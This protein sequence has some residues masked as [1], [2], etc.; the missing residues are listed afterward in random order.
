MAFLKGP[1]KSVNKE[2]MDMIDFSVGV[3]PDGQEREDKIA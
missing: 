1:K 2:D 3:E